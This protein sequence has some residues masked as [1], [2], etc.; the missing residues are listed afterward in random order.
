[1]MEDVQIEAVCPDSQVRTQDSTT[2]DYKAPG[3]ERR[4]GRQK[5]RHYDRVDPS[6]QS[7][8]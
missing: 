5:W 3:K 4:R 1:M 8:G 7:L 2:M 6:L